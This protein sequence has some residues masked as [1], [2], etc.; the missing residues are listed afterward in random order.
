MLIRFRF[1]LSILLVT[2]TTVGCAGSKTATAPYPN[3]MIE[4]IRVRS[5]NLAVTLLGIAGQGS[6]GTLVEDPGWFEYVIEIE[7][8]SS[9]GF[10]IQNVKLLN[11]DGRYVDSASAYH[12]IIAPPDVGVELAGDVAG[13][14]AGIAAGQLIPY[15]GVIFS[16]L[17]NAVSISSAEAKANAS[18]IFML[19][20]L[21]NVELA[22]AG[23]VIGSAF[24]PNIARPKIL[25]VDYLHDG[26]G[27]RMEI[28]LSLQRP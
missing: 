27:Y 12:Q 6:E 1:F 18:R 7:N 16:M 11:M 17:S 24:L 22:P 10:I 3:V 2:C 26:F 21:K 14:V 19:R 25:V 28:P 23:K 9:S 5:T 15:G 4:P 8:L 20:V 13:T